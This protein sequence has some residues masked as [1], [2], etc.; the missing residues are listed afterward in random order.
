MPAQLIDA[1]PTEYSDIPTGGYFIQF[2]ELVIWKPF[3]AVILTSTAPR[4]VI[5]MVTV[6]D[7]G[8]PQF[9]IERERPLTPEEI[10]HFTRLVKEAERE[11]KRAQHQQQRSTLAQHQKAIADSTGGRVLP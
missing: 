11:T 9:E 8:L 1:E 6:G 3:N 10:A 2:R 5:F 4:Y 7:T